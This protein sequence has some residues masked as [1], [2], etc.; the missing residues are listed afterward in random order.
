MTFTAELWL[1]PGKGGWHFVTLP[2]EIAD[3][4]RARTAGQRRGFGSARVHVTLGTTSWETSV[5][6]DSKSSSYLLPVKAEA[7]RRERVEDGDTVTVALE[8]A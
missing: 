7:R 4:V 8:L 6:P 1:Y 2:P 5:F 3:E